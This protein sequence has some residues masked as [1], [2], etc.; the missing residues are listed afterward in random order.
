[1]IIL[2]VFKYKSEIMSVSFPKFKIK[3]NA[4]FYINIE[5]TLQKAVYAQQL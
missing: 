1:M 5:H 4:A 3:E 2:S